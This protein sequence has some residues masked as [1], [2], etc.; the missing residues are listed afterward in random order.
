MAQIQVWEKE[1]QDPILVTKNEKPQNDVLRFLK[2]LKKNKKI[3]LENL[4]I[5]DLGSGTGRNSNYLASFGNNVFGM[6]ISNFAIKLAKEKMNELNI[7][8]NYFP[9]SMGEKFPFENNYFDF[10]LDVTSSNSLSEKERENYLNETRRVL[11]TGGNF[12]VRALC[13]DG[14]KNAKK[15]LKLFPG[16][17]KDTYQMPELNLV[18]RVFS[19]DDFRNLYGKYFEIEKITKRFGY[20]RFKGQ[21]YKRNY[22]LAYLAKK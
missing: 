9:R 11:K 10:I 1:Y 21:S 2:Y 14:D 17:E 4:N 18:E 15:L 22:L 16:K 20:A 7:N 8:V 6:E 12:F 5:L 19:E 3:N 13:K